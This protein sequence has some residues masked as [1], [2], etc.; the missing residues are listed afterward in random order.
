[1]H[2]RDIL[3]GKTTAVSFEFFPPRSDAAAAQLF[4]AVS[5][6]VPL[7]PAF[8]SVTYGAGGSA[9]DKRNGGL[10]EAFTREPIDGRAGKGD[11][12]DQP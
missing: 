12:W 3:N 2:I 8:V 5:E 4:A 1:M 11:Q 7:K 6:L 9:R 10:G